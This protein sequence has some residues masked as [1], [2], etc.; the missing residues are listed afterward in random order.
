MKKKQT[1][2]QKS[3]YQKY[4]PLV[5]FISILCMSVGYAI[6]NSISLDISGEALA[7]NVEGVYITEVNYVSNNNADTSNSKIINAHGTLLNSDIT[8][9]ST[10]KTSSIIPQRGIIYE[11]TN[12]TA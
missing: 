5:I 7:K 4:F 2:A 12:I 8:L 11:T 1:K 3:N 9:S 10:Y 6:I